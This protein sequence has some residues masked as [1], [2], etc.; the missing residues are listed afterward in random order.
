MT[1]I[2][3]ERFFANTSILLTFDTSKKTGYGHLR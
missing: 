1:F 3:V 2:L